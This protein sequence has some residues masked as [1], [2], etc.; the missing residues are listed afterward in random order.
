MEGTR[1]GQLE[2][3]GQVSAAALSES[4]TRAPGDFLDVK[5]Q[6]SETLSW[7]VEGRRKASSLVSYG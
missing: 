7:N 5:L 2:G 3:K 6:E 4:V 1:R